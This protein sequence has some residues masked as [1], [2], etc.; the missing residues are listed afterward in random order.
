MAQLPMVFTPATLP[1]LALPTPVAALPSAD[2]GREDWFV[3]GSA[4]RKTVSITEGVA[5]VLIG[6]DTC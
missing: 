1:S 4:K 2:G 6:L 3:G 5:F